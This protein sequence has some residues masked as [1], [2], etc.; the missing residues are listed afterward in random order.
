LNELLAE[1]EDGFEPENVYDYDDI[2]LAMQV[3]ARRVMTTPLSP[4]CG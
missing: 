4:T 1:I 3:M 2:L